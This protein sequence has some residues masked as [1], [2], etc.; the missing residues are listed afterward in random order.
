MTIQSAASG[1]YGERLQSN[2][3][4]MA[5]RLAV[6]G[7]DVYTAAAT[8]LAPAESTLSKVMPW[9]AGVAAAGHALYGITQVFTET[10]YDKHGEETWD[11]RP[12]KDYAVGSGH[13]ITAAGFATL[14]FG[15]GPWALPILAIGQATTL[16]GEFVGR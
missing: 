5:G 14:A 7:V 13:L 6:G 4:K 1:S 16:L 15:L 9:A 8:A 2:R 3:L 10:R 11:P 12:G